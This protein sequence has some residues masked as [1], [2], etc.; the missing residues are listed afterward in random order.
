MRTAEF[1]VGAQPLID[2]TD[3]LKFH[4]REL[5]LSQDVQ[6]LQLRQPLPGVYAGYNRPTQG[7]VT[8]P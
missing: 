3:E 6:P 8:A 1:V 7:E 2:E 5:E 4:M